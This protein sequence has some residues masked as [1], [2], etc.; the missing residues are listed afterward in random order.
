[1]IQITN[2][3]LV[4]AYQA[5]HKIG[6]HQGCDPVAALKAARNKRILLPFV[7]TRDEA[8]Q[9]L[10]KECTVCQ[11]D[12][13]VKRDDM[14]NVMFKS[15]EAKQKWTEGFQNINR[16]LVEVEICAFGEEE[17]KMLQ[18]TPNEMYGLLPLVGNI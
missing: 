7:E 14:G 18:A 6:E 10:L 2:M 4:E 3:E 16:A 13:D 11:E 12:G 17:L 5:L 8:V 15:E 1:M 9:K